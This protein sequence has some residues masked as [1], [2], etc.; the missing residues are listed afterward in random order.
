MKRE[1]DSQFCG[2]TEVL[3]EEE[4]ENELFYAYELNVFE[5]DL[6]H[7]RDVL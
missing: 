1:V 2:M 4:R 5:P 3:Q 6:E 7:G